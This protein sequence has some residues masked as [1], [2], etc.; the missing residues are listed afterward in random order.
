MAVFR[1]LGAAL[2]LSMLAMVF[3]TTAVSQTTPGPIDGAS[4][5][6]APIDGQHDFDFKMGRWKTHIQRLLHPLSGSTTWVELNG[7]VVVRKVWNG[8][9]SLEEIE[10]DGPTGHFEGLTLF[11]YNPESQQWSMNFANS[12]QGTLGQPSI[13][14]FK[15]GR[16]EFLDQE[17]FNGRAILVRI[18]WFNITENS[19]HFEQS[20]SDDG[21]KTWEP[22]FVATVT[23]DSQHESE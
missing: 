13:G 11:M 10:A 6:A 16:G 18:V 8:R 17:T 21:G 1:C 19:H 15:D 2:S 4:T 22:N 12:K 9:A 7:S 5:A 23:R 14:G 3:P 20:F